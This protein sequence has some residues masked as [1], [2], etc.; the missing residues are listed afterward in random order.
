VDI[1]DSDSE[2]VPD[3]ARSNLASHEEAVSESAEAVSEATPLELASVPVAVSEAMI[4]DSAS[5]KEAVPEATPSGSASAS[6]E[7]ALVPVATP[8]CSSS[9]VF[10]NRCRSIFY[11]FLDKYEKAGFNRDW[12]YAGAGITSNQ[13]R[14]QFH[15]PIPYAHVYPV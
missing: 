4:S 10:K 15:H 5:Y 2:A 9:D 8:P 3:A 13:V 11:W 7:Q 14:K 6:H 12:S 1:V